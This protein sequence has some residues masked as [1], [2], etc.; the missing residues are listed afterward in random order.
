MGASGL[1]RQAHPRAEMILGDVHTEI[2][3]FLYMLTRRV[4]KKLRP[5]DRQLHTSD[6]RRLFGSSLLCSSLGQDVPEEVVAMSARDLE[7]HVAL[8][9]DGV[10]LSIPP[11]DPI[12]RANF[13]HIGE[14][15][16]WRKATEGEEGAVGC[17][18]PRQASA[19]GARGAALGRDRCWRLRHRHIPQDKEA[20]S[21]RVGPGA[22]S[23]EVGGHLQGRTA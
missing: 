1:L 20:V 8:C 23:G 4:G 6:L 11:S 18:G 19:L 15:H 17:E 9:M 13:C 14:T 3:T 2:H 21:G 22:E 16:M 10:V 12:D 7:R 5:C